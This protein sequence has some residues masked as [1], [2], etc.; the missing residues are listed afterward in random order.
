MKSL[1]NANDYNGIV[2]RINKLTPGTRA[3]WGK[4]DVAQML[5]HVNETLSVARGE[6]V[7]KR[8]LIGRIL[9]PFLKSGYVS[10]K[11]FKQDEPTAKEFIVTTPQDFAKEKMHALEQLKAFHEGGEAGA[12]KHPHGFFGELTPK[13]WGETQW[14]HLDHHLKQFGM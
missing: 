12:T 1:F 14:K 9:G 5:R 4:M 10:D 8:L 6:K 2:G 11:P 7:I 13:Q 3:Q